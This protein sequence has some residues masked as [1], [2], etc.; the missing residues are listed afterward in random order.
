MLNIKQLHEKILY[1]VV[2]CRTDKAGGS[3]TIIYS[4]PDPKNPEEYLTFILTNEHVI[5]D[6]ITIK[7]EFDSLVKKDIKKEFFTK[8]RIDIFDYVYLSNVVSSNTHTADIVAYDRSHDI[9]LLK[10]NSPNKL[11]NVATL[12]NRKD[13]DKIKLFT[14]V[15]SCGA[16]LSHEHFANLGQI[17]YLKEFI[18]NKLYWMSN[19]N[20][21]FGNSGGAV[22]LAE[23]GEFV[24]VPARVTNIQLGFGMDV[25]SWMGFFIPMSRIYEFFDEQELQFIYNPNEDFYASM[26]KRRLK[27]K[28]GLVE[29]AGIKPHPEKKS[30]RR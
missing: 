21:I 2:R 3:G 25:V 16:S 20:C 18:D 8:I 4:Q 26:D 22:F 23:T 15:Y 30:T 10:L 5:R 1:P 14:Q 19:S 24:G 7:E 13:I 29:L 27:Q 9:A 28:T 17:T 12:L 6:A 11:D